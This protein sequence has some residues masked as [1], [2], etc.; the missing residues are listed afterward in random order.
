MAG[1]RLATSLVGMLA[2]L[3]AVPA[4]AAPPPAAPTVDST[5]PAS[6]A[7]V[8]NPKVIGTAAGGSTVK[9][10]TNA[11]CTGTEVASGTAAEFASPGID[12]TVADDSTTTFHATATD[13]NGTSVCSS[14]SVTYV[15]DST[16]PAL[17]TVD[18]TD[19]ASPANANNPKVKGTAEAGS[20]VKLYTDLDCTTPASDGA[21]TG[22][23]SGT[24]AEF[25]SPGIVV[26]VADDS[27]TT[28]YA[29]ATDAAGNVSQCSSTSAEYVEDSKADPPTFSATNPASPANENDP[30]IKGTAETGSTVKLYIKSDCSGTPVAS[31]PESAFSS[32]GI[33]VTVADDSTTAFYGTVTDEAANIS[34]CST[35]SITYIEDSTP[36]EAPTL[37]ATNPLGPAN[38]NHPGVV[39]TAEGGAT[40]SLYATADCSGAPMTSGSESDFALSGLTVQVA[41]NTFTTFHAKATDRAGNASACST[42]SVSYREDSTA[43][44]T[45]VTFA[46]AGKTRDRTP[47]FLFAAMGREPGV[48]FVC[49]LDD[50]PYKPCKSPKTYA[51]LRYRRHLFHVKAVDRAGNADRSA[52]GRGFV[53]L[54]TPRS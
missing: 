52:A 54:R 49:K 3:L 10:Y 23:A 53:V 43:P 46:P 7:N 27:T 22:D 33:T 15:E 11:G 32:D 34:A 12:V 44:D 40:V 39:G 24:E 13:V 2:A 50:G 51:K 37:V 21:G 42:S 31:G 1:F 30:K 26:T 47:T 9:L 35:A 28:F 16:D 20:T 4:L 25:A 17:P 38:E 36:P 8:N 29:T 19:P 5:A 48:S 45:R 41:D 18:S 14:T 6:P